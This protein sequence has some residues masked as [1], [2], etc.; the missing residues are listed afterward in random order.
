MKE[1]A[2]PVISRQRQWQLR[3]KRKGNC[4]LCGRRRNG[5]A[6]LCDGCHT[7][8]M[9]AQRA[10]RGFKPWRPGSRGVPPLEDRKRR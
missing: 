2:P 1:K 6:W 7:K 9:I 10:R 8:Q 3:Q 5:K 4:I